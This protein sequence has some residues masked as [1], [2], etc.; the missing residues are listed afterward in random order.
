MPPEQEACFV[1][2]LI[3]VHSSDLTDS[4]YFMKTGW[5]DGQKEGKK[6]KM[7]GGREGVKREVF[8]WTKKSLTLRDGYVKEFLTRISKQVYRICFPRNLLRW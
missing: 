6:G 8:A 7:E 2:H 5:M 1:H 3:L 4:M